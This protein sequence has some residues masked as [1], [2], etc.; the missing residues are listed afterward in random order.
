M[1]LYRK[2]VSINIVLQNVIYSKVPQPKIIRKLSLL[3]MKNVDLLSW[4]TY[5]SHE[6]F[7][8]MIHRASSPPESSF[9]FDEEK[10]TTQ[11]GSFLFFKVSLVPINRLWVNIWLELKMLIERILVAEESDESSMAGQT[12]MNAGPSPMQRPRDSSSSSEEEEKDHSEQSLFWTDVDL[13]LCRRIF[14]LQRFQH[15]TNS[16]FEVW[17]NQRAIKR[18]WGYSLL[19]FIYI[20]SSCPLWL[21]SISSWYTQSSHKYFQEF[22]LLQ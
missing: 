22:S 11:I 5:H 16:Y 20:L 8:T 4:R 18:L 13:H 15:T 2:Y 19:V 10:K 6:I 12:F 1:K 17:R 21:P 3:N 7:R 14:M 9:Y